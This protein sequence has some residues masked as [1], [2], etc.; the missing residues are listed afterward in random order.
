MPGAWD[1]V[2]N[3][4]IVDPAEAASRLHKVHSQA[5]ILILIREQSDWLQSVYKYVMSQLP[6]NCRTF[7]DYCTTPSGIVL[8]HA[9]HFDRTISAYIDLFGSKRIRVLRFE[10]IAAAPNRFVSELCSFVGI[11]EQPLP[12]R[13]ENETH[14]Q[15]ARTSAIFPIH[16]AIAAKREKRSK[17]TCDAPDS[18]RARNNPVIAADPHAARYLCRQQSA[19]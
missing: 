7:S 9:G 11:S 17:T 6:W 19:Y 15:I 14:A 3:D 2:K 10:D 18:G 1:R 12:G 13:R 16:R 4:I 8:L 5:K